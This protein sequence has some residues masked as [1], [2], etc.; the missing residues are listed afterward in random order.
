M[1]VVPATAS[2]ANQML[3]RLVSSWQ[4]IAQWSEPQAQ[5]VRQ[6]FEQAGFGF[7]QHIV[8]T[9]RFEVVVWVLAKAHTADISPATAQIRV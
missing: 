6:R 5:A 1:V 3:S 4:S 9:R 2:R 7:Q 8:P